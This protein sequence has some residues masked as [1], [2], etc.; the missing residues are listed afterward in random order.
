MW[1][2]ASRQSLRGGVQLHCT[3]ARLQ[4]SARLEAKLSPLHMCC[5]PRPGEGAGTTTTSATL[6]P[7]GD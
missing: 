5:P 2:L 6:P 4:R 3:A 7:R 1:I